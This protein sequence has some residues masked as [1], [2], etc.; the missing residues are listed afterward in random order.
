MLPVLFSTLQH[1]YCMISHYN[2]HVFMTPIESCWKELSN[3]ILVDVGVQKLTPNHPFPLQNPGI[4]ASDRFW[5]SPPRNSYCPQFGSL[6]AIT[7][8]LIHSWYGPLVGMVSTF[9]FE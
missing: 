6:S 1:F 3:C 4:A 9:C 8:P 5:P 7:I 2:H